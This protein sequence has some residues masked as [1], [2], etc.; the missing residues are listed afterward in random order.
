MVQNAG[1]SPP[2]VPILSPLNPVHTLLPCF[3]KIL[4]VRWR[5]CPQIMK[6]LIM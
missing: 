1:K 5:V 6:L 2:L 3:L 4:R